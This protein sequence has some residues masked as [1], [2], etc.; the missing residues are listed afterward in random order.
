MSSVIFYFSTR[1]DFF[2]LSEIPTCDN[3]IELPNLDR[4]SS[5]LSRNPVLLTSNQNVI[6][7]S[8]DYSEITGLE[9]LLA[10]V[11]LKLIT[12]ILHTARHYLLE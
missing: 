3:L 9:A 7:K 10:D 11:C 8:L 12:D 4:F 5:S 1:S 6:V 2:L